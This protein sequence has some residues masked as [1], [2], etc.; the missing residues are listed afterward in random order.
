MVIV[1]FMIFSLIENK[2]WLTVRSKPYV[3]FKSEAIFAPNTRLGENIG[4]T[5]ATPGICYDFQ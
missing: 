2:R 3:K 1:I 4:P 5:E